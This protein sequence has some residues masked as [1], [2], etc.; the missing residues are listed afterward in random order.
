VSTYQIGIDIGGTHTDAVVLVDDGRHVVAKAPSTPHDYSEGV[1]ASLEV[2]AGEMGTSVADLLQAT[3]V[4]VNGSTVATN[5]IA[6]LS[7]ARTGVI[8][9][10]GFEDTLRIARSARRNGVFDFHRQVPP[11]QIVPR[12]LVRG[13]PERVDYRG[14]VVVALQRADAEAAV[15][16]LLDDG[17]ETIAV[18][19]LWSFR[20]PAHEQLLGDVIRELAP[21]M[22]H[23]LS[24]EV[25]PVIREYERMVTTV[26]NSYAGPRVTA[27]TTRLASRLEDLGL[28]STPMIMHSEGGYMSFAAAGRRPV[29][30]ILSGPAAGA[31]GAAKL[32]ASLGL[33]NVITADMGGT[34]YDTALIHRGEVQKRR[35]ALVDDFET[36]LSLVDVVAIGS[37]GGSIAWIDDR[38]QPNVGPQSAG[39]DPGPACYGKGGT[40]PTVTDALLVLGLVSPER[41][42]AGR[43]RIDPEL[44]RRAIGE[45]FAVPLGRSVEE[46]AQWIYTLTVARMSNATRSVSIERGFDP[47]QFTF[48]S[49]GGTSPLFQS[50]ICR[51]LRIGDIVVPGDSSGFC[52]RG[53]LEA[54]RSESYVESLYWTS[55][56]PLDELNP[57]FERL[58]ARARDDFAA[59][60]YGAGDLTV[61]REGDLRFAGQWSELTI[62][63]P[64][65][66]LGADEARLIEERFVETYETLYG[67]GTAW[68]GAP[69]EIQNCRLS[70]VA[71]SQTFA[72][73]HRE[74]A[75]GTSGEPIELRRAYVPSEGVMREVAVYDG[76]RLPAAW[77]ARGPALVEL[78]YT[79]VYVAP[80]EAVAL[81]AADNFRITRDGEGQ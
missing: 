43:E 69:I 26:F 66:R 30:L 64:P 15:R 61:V 76:D 62:P 52:A 18:C 44:A 75:S 2:A 32:G 20:N 24:S 47:R 19:L 5:V 34:S 59:Q 80:D 56:R 21:G 79:V 4:F 10:A 63:L 17:V 1:V 54:D 38:G 23:S 81:D 3:A 72:V 74:R 37:G 65:G 25:H 51:S 29:S 60:G 33:D 8:T 49:F 40:Q 13:V 36:G 6:Q 14:E 35:R 28:R 7:G 77:S 12:T 70:V 46:A 41:F 39:A 68:T 27:Y 73:A 57:V 58:E 9:T 71:P 50:E 53:L 45:R 11:P 78:P 22:H 55:E 48:F 42:L 67:P 16:A 31:I